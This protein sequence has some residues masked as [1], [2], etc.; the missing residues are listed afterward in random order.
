MIKKLYILDLHYENGRRFISFDGKDFFLASIKFSN[1][2]LNKN[3]CNV[4]INGIKEIY[5]VNFVDRN[6]EFFL[7]SDNFRKLIINVETRFPNRRICIVKNCMIDTEVTPPVLM[8]DN[9]FRPYFFRANFTNRAFQIFSFSR[10][11][12][13]LDTIEEFG[14]TTKTACYILV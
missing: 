7:Q 9:P 1:I 5:R 6:L 13:W 4:E 8:T 11:N 10:F 3:F 14:G 12:I 2:T